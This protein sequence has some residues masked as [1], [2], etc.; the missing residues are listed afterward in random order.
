MTAKKFEVYFEQK[1]KHKLKKGVTKVST[2]ISRHIKDFHETMANNFE[3]EY[4]DQLTIY[5]LFVRQ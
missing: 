3:S 2:S 1:G 5:M 4:F